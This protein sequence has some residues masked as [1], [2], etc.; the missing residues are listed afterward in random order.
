MKRKSPPPPRPAPARGRR[1]A[2]LNRA[3]QQ[4]TRRMLAKHYRAKY[5]VR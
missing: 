5:G 2:P 3:L 4:Q 1:A